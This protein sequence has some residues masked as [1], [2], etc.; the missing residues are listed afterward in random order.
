MTQQATPAI[1]ATNLS[2]KTT[3]GLTLVEPISFHIDNGQALTILGETGSG[4]SLLAQ[5]IMGALPDGLVACGELAID[6][7]SVNLA[8]MHAL[9]GRRLAMLAQEP[10]RSLDPTMN[11]LEQTA[12]GYH[13]VAGLDK[14]TAQQKSQDFLTTLGLGAYNDYYPHELSGGMAQRAAFCVA[15][16]GGA[17][18]VLADEPTKGLD[19]KNR[20]IVIDLLCQV[21]ENG[22]TLLTITHDIDVATALCQTPN[23]QLMVMKKG[24]LLEAGDGKTLIKNPQSD[25]AHKLIS[26]APSNWQMP[27]KPAI[28]TQTQLVLDNI[29]I[30]RGKNTL[31]SGLSL[32][33]HQGETIGIVGRSGIG[34]SSLGDVI[35]GLLAPSQGK[36]TWTTPPKRHQV[37]KLYQDPPSAFAPHL[38]LGRLLDDVIDKHSLDRSR[39]P[40]LLEK[41]SL[42]PELLNRTAQNVSGGEL[43]R[44]AILRCLLLNPVLLFADEVTSRLDPITQQE[45]MDLLVE[46]CKEN[47]CTLILVSHDPHLTEYY[48]DT[49]VDLSEYTKA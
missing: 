31:F 4:K 22:G 5:G 24:V 33:I 18:I 10:T 21:V 7:K 13:F 35:C 12:E 32:D 23:S 43:Q 19:D 40:Y 15:S 36:L 3:T 38:P 42:T 8:D 46:Q 47:N 41:L 17:T 49:K 28:T 1:L 9:W 29:A 44:I 6:G 39:I 25:Y 20:Q 37:L 14:A 11:I 45:T 26:S 27:A 48:C 34:K 16:S 30:K 2:V